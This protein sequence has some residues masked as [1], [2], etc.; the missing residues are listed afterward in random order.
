MKPLPH[1]IELQKVL[2]TISEVAPHLVV[3]PIYMF[4]FLERLDC[5]GNIRKNCELIGLSMTS[6]GDFKCENK[7][8][9]NTIVHEVIHLNYWK[10]G[11]NKE[12]DVINKMIF[13]RVWNR[14]QKGGQDGQS[15][16]GIKA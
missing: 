14:L 5:Y 15:T 12:F 8:F 1:E 13:D 7:Q 9:V 6:I 3:P 10:L 4:E 11:H 16:E 2:D